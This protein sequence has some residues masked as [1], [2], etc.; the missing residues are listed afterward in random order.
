[1][2]GG[3]NH[4]FPVFFIGNV[5]ADKHCRVTDFPGDRAARLLVHIGDRNPRTLAGQPERILLAYAAASAG[6][7]YNL[8]LHSSHSG[9]PYQTLRVASPG[10]TAAD[11]AEPPA[12]RPDQTQSASARPLT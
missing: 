5:V 4:G 6:G 3:G 11:A 12:R 10:V 8:F 1:L 9:F 2:L 7:Y